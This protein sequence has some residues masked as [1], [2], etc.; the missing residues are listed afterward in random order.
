MIITI[1]L[2]Q[3]LFVKCYFK[4]PNLTTRHSRTPHTTHKELSKSP[5]P[6]WPLVTTH[7]HP[8][9]SFLVRFPSSIKVSSFLLFTSWSVSMIFLR[10]KLLKHFYFVVF[11]LT[12]FLMM[13]LWENIFRILSLK[14]VLFYP[15][16]FCTRFVQLLIA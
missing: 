3:M 8:F 12:M 1:I 11:C 6:N 4:S 14:L 5:L 10:K 15:C 2:K 13:G 9:L 16:G 7:K